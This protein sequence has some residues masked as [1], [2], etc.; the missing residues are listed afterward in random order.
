MKVLKY[1]F[2]LI[3][4]TLSASLA[5][6]NF[7]TDCKF[8]YRVSSEN[9][10]DSISQFKDQKLSGPQLGVSVTSIDAQVETLRAACYFAEPAD[11]RNCVEKYQTI[12]G[13]IKAKVNA[14][15][16]ISG[17]QTDVNYSGIESAIV[18]AKFKITDLRCGF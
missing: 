14:V 18:S 15:D 16:L 11:N 1:S 17:K 7:A 8:A 3:A 5:Q 4:C 2:F 13:A 9:L 12:Y 10:V 6:A